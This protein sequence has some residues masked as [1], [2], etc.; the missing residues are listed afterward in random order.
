MKIHLYNNRNN[1][2]NPNTNIPK[3]RNDEIWMK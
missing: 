3:D 1:N 2:E